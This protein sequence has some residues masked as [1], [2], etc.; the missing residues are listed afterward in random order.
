MQE[1]N[2][3]D[4]VV[5]KNACKVLLAIPDDILVYCSYKAHFNLLEFVNKQNILEHS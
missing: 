2:P 3:R 1:V 4:F 5:R